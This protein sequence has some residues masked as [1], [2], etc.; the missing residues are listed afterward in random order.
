MS[1]ED[2]KRLVDC[3]FLVFRH[4]PD[5]D[6]PIL[7]R[8]HGQFVV[9]TSRTNSFRSFL[10]DVARGDQ[11]NR[12]FLPHSSSYMVND[13][14]RTRFRTE[15]ASALSIKTSVLNVF[16]PRNWNRIQTPVINKKRFVVTKNEWN[17][18]QMWEVLANFA[19]VDDIDTL[20]TSDCNN[21]RLRGR[22]H[23]RIQSTR[24]ELGLQRI[25]APFRNK[26]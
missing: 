19:A 13:R 7:G 21:V 17:L 23:E 2:E 24:V 8:Y 22:K 20:A 3:L 1:I 12:L 18:Y 15:Q 10:A 4:R 14:R 6:V 25:D 11:T 9:F 26:S 16:I 5:V